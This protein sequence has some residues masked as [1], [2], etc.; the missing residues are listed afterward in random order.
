MNEGW[1]PTDGEVVS[2]PP[3]DSPEGLAAPP[4]AATGETAAAEPETL[5]AS[6]AEKAQEIERL[7]DRLLRLHA[8]FDNYKKRVA[9][10]REEF[11]KFAHEGLVLEF[12]PIL[13]NLERAVALAGGDAPRGLLEGLQMVIRLFHTTLGKA[14]VTAVDPLGQPFDPNFHQAV[15]QVEV[16]E[17][18]DHQVLEVIQKGYLLE[19]RVIRPAMV[20]V[21]KVR[22]AAGVEAAGESEQSP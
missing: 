13:D 17:G 5:K 9:R 20:K 11:V 18:P 1:K 15:Q 19:G 21:S 8:E 4:P 12:L 6:L 2:G 3:T 22:G 14:G 16:A 10:E 7:Q